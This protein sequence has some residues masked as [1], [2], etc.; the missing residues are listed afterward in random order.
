[1]SEHDRYRE[2]LPAYAL[3]TLAADERVALE[4]HLHGCAACR[5][6]LAWLGP[7]VETL[8]ISVPGR[9]PPRGLRRR[10]LAAARGETRPQPLTTRVARLGPP[11]L[12]AGAAALALAAVAITAAI[13]ELGG[14]GDGPRTVPIEV[15]AGEAPR[16]SG[17]LVVDDDRAT[18]EVSGLPRL[19]DDRV[20]Q[21]WLER[22]GRIEPSSTFI[23][24][25]DGAGAATIPDLAGASKVMVTAEP[26]GGSETP[27]TAPLITASPQ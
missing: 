1:M 17:T 5:E 22:D 6:E 2:E 24:D 16:A 8:A 4:A 26:R 19:S 9:T 21:A 15:A 12:A 23:V 20:Y 10:T 27:S 3:G 7:A 18:L 13:G 25:R 14:S 11:R